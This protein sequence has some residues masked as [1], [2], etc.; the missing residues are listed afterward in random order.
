MTVLETDVWRVVYLVYVITDMTTLGVCVN[1][2]PIT[3]L[4]GEASLTPK[5]SITTTLIATL[6]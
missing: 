4:C 5:P 1:E 6:N 3:S 2:W